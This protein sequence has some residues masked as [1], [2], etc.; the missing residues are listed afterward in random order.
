MQEGGEAVADLT[1]VVDAVDDDR[2]GVAWSGNE[3]GGHRAELVG[4]LDGP[5]PQ[6]TGF[7]RVAR[8]DVAFEARLQAGYEVAAHLGEPA[9]DR[10][11]VFLEDRS[12]DGVT[13][14][15]DEPVVARAS[16]RFRPG[17]DDAVGRH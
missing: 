13:G 6:A 16:G 10:A 3:P 7:E 17:E 4:H 1:V 14:L 11:L 15:P 8:V 9:R 5:E 12:D 2:P